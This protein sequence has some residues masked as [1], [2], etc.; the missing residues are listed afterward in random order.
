MKLKHLFEYQF[1]EIQQKTVKRLPKQHKL[2]FNDASVLRNKKVKHLGS[3]AFASAYANEDRPE[4]VRKVS[5]QSSVHDGYM[6]FVKALKDSPEFGNPYFP[7]F[8]EGSEY[9]DMETH[10]MVRRTVYSVKTERLQR[11]E[12]LTKKEVEAVLERWYG[13]NWNAVASQVV[14]RIDPKSKFNPPGNWKHPAFQ[15]VEI[16]KRLI[17][18]VHFGAGLQDEDLAKAIGF[19]QTFQGSGIGEPDIS[20]NNIMYKRSPYGIQLVFTDPVA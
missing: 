1:P 15:L 6:K 18:G 10:S 9:K 14:Q 20:M 7:K 3:G 4:D 5:G 19:I 11:L 17:R 2:A 8:R 16:L 13:K 12:D